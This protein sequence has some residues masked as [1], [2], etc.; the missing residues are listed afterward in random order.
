[1]S[2]SF[3]FLLGFNTIVNPILNLN[4]AEAFN[5]FLDLTSYSKTY[6]THEWRVAFNSFLDLTQLVPIM[7]IFELI[8]FQFLLGFNVILTWDR[9]K[10]RYGPFNSFLD[11]TDVTLYVTWEYKFNFQFLLGF[12]FQYAPQALSHSYQLSIPSWI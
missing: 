11:L 4:I 1:M 3:Q 5:S 12:N 7:A 2:D 9:M 10:Q 6:N 8:S